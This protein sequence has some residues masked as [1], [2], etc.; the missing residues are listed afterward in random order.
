[1]SKHYRLKKEAIPFFKE[2]L[3]TTVRTFD[4]WE[5]LNVDKKALEEVK[6]MFISYGI[7]F[8]DGDYNSHILGGWSEKD[9]TRFHFTLN[10]PSVKY[11]EY[12]RFGKGKIVREIMDKI[13]RDLDSFYE[14]F[15]ND[16]LLKEE[17]NEQ[18]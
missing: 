14:D 16:E 4:V 15:I 3:T 13:Q 12:S 5:K 17:S 6:P 18:A 2:D 10:F 11:Q 9:K 1:M 7:P 8:K